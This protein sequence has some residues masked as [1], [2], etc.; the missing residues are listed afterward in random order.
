MWRLLYQ[1]SYRS[2]QYLVLSSEWTDLGKDVSS[3]A[4]QTFEQLDQRG[5]ALQQHAVRDVQRAQLQE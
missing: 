1:L 3:V 2:T 4:G 5:E